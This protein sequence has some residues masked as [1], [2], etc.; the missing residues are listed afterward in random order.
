MTKSILVFA[1]ALACSTSAYA[2]VTT[3]TISPTPT[4]QTPVL[5]HGEWEGT[6]FAGY[7]FLQDYKFKTIVSAKD[8][9]TP[10]NAPGVVEMHYSSSY[11]LGARATQNLGDFFAASL[12]YG[13]SDQPLRL[14]NVSQ[15]VPSLYLSHFVHSLTYN[16]SFSPMARDKRFRPHIAIG[17]GALLFHIAE[18]SRTDARDRGLDLEDSW[19]VLFNYGVGFKY[20]AADRM[21]ITADVQGRT[22]RV[23][24]YGLPKYSRLV[25]GQFQ[26]AIT[27]TGLMHAWQVNLGF[28]YQWPASW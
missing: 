14:V 10:Q 2:Q 16:V 21:A 5:Q 25:E 19:E 24:T 8:E 26:P 9:A 15:R 20:L 17:T 6:F 23:P 12:E 4:T 3:P 28:A 18:D 22:S 1:L 27:T 11:R 13:F 7:A